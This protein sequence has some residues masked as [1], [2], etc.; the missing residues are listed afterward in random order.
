M[1]NVTD[2]LK[3][4]LSGL[5]AGERAELARFLINSLD[6]GADAD[7]EDAWDAELTR[8]IDDIKSGAAIGEPIDKVF[9]ELREKYS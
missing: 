8:R 7:A 6:Q 4:Q 5:S 1:T 3:S 2:E 9:G